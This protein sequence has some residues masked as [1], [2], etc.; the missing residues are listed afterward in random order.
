MDT[1]TFDELNALASRLRQTI[2]TGQSELVAAYATSRDTT[3]LLHGRSTLVDGILRDLWQS[4]AM[5]AEF[6]L[7]AVGGYGRGEL[8]PASD[9]DLLILLH[10]PACTKAQ[11]RLETLVGL[12]WDIGLE[13]GHSVR[14]IDECLSEADADITVQTTLLEARFLCGNRLLFEDFEGL[15]HAQFDAQAFFK[16]KKLE[17]TERHIRYQETPYSL[18]P[19]T[20]ES[21]GGLR[22][23]QVIL[24]VCKAAGYGERWEDLAAHGFITSSEATQLYECTEVLQKIRI[25][26]HVVARRREDRLLF[27]FQSAVAER[28]G[29]SA[30][31]NR[32][33]SEQLMQ[34]YYRNAKTVTQLNTILLQNIAAALFPSEIQPLEPINPRFQMDHELL[35]VTSETIFEDRP[36]AIFESFHLM[37]QHPEL[38][39]MTARTLRALWR[40]RDLITPEFRA[41]PENRAAFLRLFQAERGIVHE[42]RRMNQYGLV[43]RYIPAFGKIV[44]QM[45]HDLFHMYTVDQHTMMVLRNLRRFTMEEYAHEYP[46]CCRLINAFERHWVLYIAA[47]FHDIAKGRGGDHS[48]LGR[49]DAREFCENHG[50]SVED[51]ELVE[52]L[53]GN[54]LVMSQVAQKED[55]SDPDVISAF[56][57]RV[58]DERHLTALYLLTVADIRGTSPKVWNNWKGKLLADL[59]N[60]TLYR[61]DTH[62][63]NLPPQGVI[64]QRQA[65]AMRLLRY[66][67]LSATVHERLWKQLDTVYF[68]RHTAEEIAWHTRSLHYRIYNDKPIVSA[69]LHEEQGLQVMVYTRDEPDLFLRL[70]GFFARAGYN[71]VDAKIHT[72]RHGYALDSFILLDTSGEEITRATI[73]YIEHELGQRLLHH[74]PADTPAS[75]RISRHVKHFPIT[76]EAVLRPDEKGTHYLLSI[77]AADRPGLLYKVASL[78]NKAHVSLHTAKITTLG[79]RVEDVFLVSGRELEQSAARIRLETQ[80][81]DELQV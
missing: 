13:I 49:V 43:G 46:M 18:E 65:D 10:E 39:G 20:K 69:R 81:V 30:T 75:G 45:Q 33:A 56:A 47:I 12:F 50:M 62:H 38:K 11:Q 78:L 35:D 71:I 34:V 66:F 59:Y 8:Y 4:L 58:K 23:L 52:W 27:D 25:E 29:Y 44:G 55:L 28:L 53:V 19:N 22:D 51:T 54:H 16:A 3:A 61:L 64:Q 26:L 5:P 17:Q 77:T 57:A 76:P 79:E 42:I 14:T 1:L 36:A 15:L 68:L 72:T 63:E 73:T 6:T 9:V 70:V 41:N 7:A 60:L 37:Q 32:R 40:A 80:L 31:E 74:A 21:P 24:W 67:A 2:K 48:E